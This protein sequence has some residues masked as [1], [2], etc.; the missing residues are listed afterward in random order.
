M[1]LKN[2]VLPIAVPLLICSACTL[3]TTRGI[4]T[5]QVP[6]FNSLVIGNNMNVN[7]FYGPQQIILKGSGNLTSIEYYLKG[8]ELTLINSGGDKDVIVDIYTHNLANVKCKENCKVNFPE[9][10]ITQSNF[11]E[12]TGQNE[13]SISMHKNVF[14][15]TLC[16]SLN[17]TSHLA[18]DSLF[19][20]SVFCTLHNFTCCNVEGYSN[21]LFLEM[22]EAARFN[23]N[24]Q[25]NNPKLSYPLSSSSCIAN[26]KNGAQA[27]ISTIY[28][29][30]ATISDDSRIYHYGFPEIIDKTLENKGDLVPKNV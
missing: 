17:D 11:L 6:D 8:E 29:L 30:D 23:M 12:L 21:K 7:I 19:S 16:I 2:M 10:F 25:D 28:H 13:A 4:I 18:I 22:T 1:N 20:T 15:D 9:G 3:N 14:V 5:L 27:W 24:F 26:V